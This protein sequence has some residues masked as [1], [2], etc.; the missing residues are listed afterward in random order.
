MAFLNIAIARIDDLAAKAT[1][2]FRRFDT[3]PFEWLYAALTIGWGMSLLAPGD[4]FTSSP[5]LSAMAALM[6][7]EY[8]GS[9]ALFVGI[10]RVY[11]L[12]AFKVAPRLFAAMAGGLLWTYLWISM[13][14][15]HGMNTGVPIYGVLATLNL[16]VFIKL[17]RSHLSPAQGGF[18][19]GL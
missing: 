4:M 5:A 19:A 2:N 13:A 1:D 12:M 18:G 9:L 7:E 3:R 17:C 15:G 10:S 6:A 11:G 8:W 14:F 16:V